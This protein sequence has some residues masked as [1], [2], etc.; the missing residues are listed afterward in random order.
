MEWLFPAVIATLTGSIVLFLAYAYLNRQEPE[1]FLG[2]WTV[3]WGLYSL[4]FLFMLSLLNAPGHPTILAGNQLCALWSAYFL[5]LGANQFS[6]SLTSRWWFIGTMV[7]SL[8]ILLATFQEVPFLWLTLPTFG[9]MAL[10]CVWTGRIFIK[11][12]HSPSFSRKVLGYTFIFWGL[13]KANYPFLQPVSWFAPW[14]YT[15][16]AILA[17]IAALGTIM[18]YFQRTRKDLSLSEERNRRILKTAMDGFWRTDTKGRLLEVNDTYCRM[19]GYD[20]HELQSFNISN[21]DA[22]LGVEDISKRI[23]GVVQTGHDRFETRHR[24]KNG[25][26][27]DVEV[28]VQYLEDEKGGQL[29]IFLRDITTI[30]KTQQDYRTLFREMLDGFALHEIIC[31]DAG[32]PVNYRFLAVN[33]AFEHMTGLKG[34]DILGKTVLEVL[35]GLEP[36]W[37]ENYGKVALT[38][39][40]ILFENESVELGKYFKVTAYCPSPMQF[41]CIFSDVTERK[42]AEGER[43]Q[44]RKQLAQAQKM[45]ALGTLASGIAHDFNNSLAA[46]MGYSELAMDELHKHEAVSQYLAAI[47]KAA[48]KARNLVRQILT[49]SRSVEGQRHIISLNLVVNE[50]KAILGRTLPKMIDVQ[51]DLQ[52]DLRKVTADSQ[53][54]ERVLINLVTNAA[55]ATQKSG[56]ISIATRNVSQKQQACEFCG[57]ILSGPHVILSVADNGSGMSPEVQAKIF[58]PFYTTKDVG[59]GTGLGLSMVYGIVTAHGGHICCRSNPGE[60][61][62][63]LIHLPASDEQATKSGEGVAKLGA[64]STGSGTILVVDDEL[65][66]RDIA[67]KMLTRN[68]YQVVLAD[69]GEKALEIY[70]KQGDGIDLVMMDLG[71]PGMGGKACLAE[72]RRRDPEA[73][74]LISSGY[75]Q[76]ELTD[77]L[78]SLGAAGMVSK[79]YRKEEMLQKIS[80]LLSARQ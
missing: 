28:S 20:R 51:Y 4:R 54:M 50:A 64:S 26:I 68:G 18:V 46:I 71:M 13:H 59:K 25:S 8:W 69:C 24:R 15:L 58:D 61:S 41:V 10:V 49:F 38:G 17:L 52:T 32:K 78:S 35:P 9:F 30:R 48:A 80:E 11:D 77:E 47:T 57:E 16:G 40:P 79:P 53:Q 27:F 72:L 21:L 42:Q 65:F 2:T 45:D 37:I 1:I 73:M 6:G 34:E 60:G 5:L 76:Y 74:V 3:S 67:N 12:E 33:P 66:V 39:E 31:D 62:E 75:I 23:Q 56:T 43:R 7:D 14:G 22:L 55:D 29:V 44:L 70:E 19:S 36:A 63:F